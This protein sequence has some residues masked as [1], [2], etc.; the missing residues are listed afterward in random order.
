V[1]VARDAFVQGMVAAATISGVVAVG[2]AVLAVTLLRNVRRAPVDEGD[3]S[4]Q[5]PAPL[6][7]GIAVDGDAA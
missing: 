6:P 4:N 3:V 2:V 5:S 7:V 1:R